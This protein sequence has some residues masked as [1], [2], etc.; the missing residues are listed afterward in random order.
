MN[1]VKGETMKKKP[2]IKEKGVNNFGI[3]QF[4]D[5]FLLKNQNNKKNKAKKANI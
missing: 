2:F 3:L 1:G 5:C 4:K